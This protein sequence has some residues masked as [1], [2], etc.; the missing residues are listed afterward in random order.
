MHL[1]GWL[2][3]ALTKKTIFARS[4]ANACP[5]GKPSTELHLD[6]LFAILAAHRQFTTDATSDQKF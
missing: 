5:N 3:V 4:N 2:L 6:T 1:Y